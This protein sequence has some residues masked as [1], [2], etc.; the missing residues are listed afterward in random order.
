MKEK[1]KK[2]KSITIYTFHID[3]YMSNLIKGLFS[4][5]F[6]ESKRENINQELDKLPPRRKKKSQRKKISS[7]LQ[8]KEITEAA[9]KKNKSFFSK[10]NYPKLRSRRNRPNQYL[11]A[12]V[13]GISIGLYVFQPLMKEIGE[14]QRQEMNEGKL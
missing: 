14:K 3:I 8:L 10:L 11:V 12:V 2:K 9:G 6:G 13:F 4:G 1:K 7:N 5:N